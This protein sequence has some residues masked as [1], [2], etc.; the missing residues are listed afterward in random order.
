MFV[1][2]LCLRLRVVFVLMV[3]WFVFCLD[4]LVLVILIVRVK[5]L[6]LLLR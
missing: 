3:D 5:F 4:V 1:L 2:L 6:K